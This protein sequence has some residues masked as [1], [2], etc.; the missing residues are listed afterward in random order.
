VTAGR[1][2]ETEAVREL[3]RMAKVFRRVATSLL[4]EPNDNTCPGLFRAGLALDR[5]ANYLV[6][7]AKVRR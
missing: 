5:R 6:K 1:V 7:K 3:R 2:T 4:D